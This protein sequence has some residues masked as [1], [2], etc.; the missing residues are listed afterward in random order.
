[1]LQ[2]WSTYS[3]LYILWIMEIRKFD[4]GKTQKT[5]PPSDATEFTL[6]SKLPPDFKQKKRSPPLFVFIVTIWEN[7][8]KH[9][10]E[11]Q[12]KWTFKYKS[13]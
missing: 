5:K 13:A 4:R 10:G 7:G 3:Q 2:P 1:M 9:K 11:E 8:A 12:R 6:H